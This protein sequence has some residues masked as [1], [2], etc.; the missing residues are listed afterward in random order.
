MRRGGAVS[1][2]LATLAGNS[3]GAAMMQ[4][5]EAVQLR[6]CPH[7]KLLLGTS[8]AADAW[9]S[10]PVELTAFTSQPA[11]DMARSR[12]LFRSPHR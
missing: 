11:G 8:D 6:R 5:H 4:A 7:A 12:S 1:L 2:W 10:A 3:V 9:L